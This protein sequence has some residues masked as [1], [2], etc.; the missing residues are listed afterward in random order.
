[1][2]LRVTHHIFVSAIMKNDIFN[3]KKDVAEFIIH[4]LEP[5]LFLPEDVIISYGMTD[6]NIYFLANGAVLVEVHDNMKRPCS[7]TELEQG[8]YFGEVSILYGSKRT[9]NVQSVSYCT[10][11]RLG[12][13]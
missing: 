9:A 1:M 8:S 6:K 4:Y 5:R 2:R 7:I 13:E 11:A 10:L 3:K 12:M